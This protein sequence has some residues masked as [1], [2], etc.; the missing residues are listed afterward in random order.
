MSKRALAWAKVA[1]ECL[2]SPPSRFVLWALADLSD[3]K[4][5]AW[6][7]WRVMCQQTGLSKS[8]LYRAYEDLVR[9]RL[10]RVNARWRAN[11]TRA[12]SSFNLLVD[13]PVHKSVHK[14]VDKS[15]SLPT[16]GTSGPTSG[17]SSPC[18]GN[19]N[20]E[21]PSIDPLIDPAEA[22]D[23]ESPKNGQ[24]LSKGLQT[25]KEIRRRTKV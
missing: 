14:S 3:D 2:A 10:M 9:H 24:S 23:Q 6:P 16:S 7:G 19:P 11:G 21:D 4:G 25:L 17:T 8:A 12:G 22:I 5:L 13:Q 18:G 15:V 20:K 1:G